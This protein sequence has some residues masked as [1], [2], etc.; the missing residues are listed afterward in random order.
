M[1]FDSN[2]GS[3]KGV[4][5]KSEWITDMLNTAKMKFGDGANAGSV[6]KKDGISFSEHLVFIHACFADPFRKS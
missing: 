6:I 3:V 4:A 2:T 1:L 5:V